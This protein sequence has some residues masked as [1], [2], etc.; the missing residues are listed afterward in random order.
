MKYFLGFVFICFSSHCY[1]ITVEDIVHQYGKPEVISA[2]NKQF[3]NRD[4]TKLTIEF[5]GV[6]RQMQRPSQEYITVKT[7]KIDLERLELKPGQFNKLLIKDLQAANRAKLKKAEENKR[8]RLKQARKSKELRLHG[9]EFDG[10][11]SGMTIPAMKKIA[12]KRQL[13]I[14][15]GNLIY[16][17]GYNQRILDSQPDQRKYTYRTKLMGKL[18][19]VT[20]SFT[21]NTRQLYQV[22]TVF[23]IN[24][25]KP[26]ER[27]YFYDSLFSQLSKKYGN[28]SHIQNKNIGNMFTRFILEP[29]VGSLMLWKPNKNTN[30]F[31]NYKKQYHLLNSFVLTYMNLSL[32]NL[33]KN[34]ITLELKQRT[35]KALSGDSG[36]L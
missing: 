5:N 27:K 16:I 19:T 12:E 29:M 31:L 34:E 14:S 13:P 18:T 24:Q 22:K 32:A 2:L 3:Q 6:I 21:K 26:E 15:P 36:R 30:I 4:N 20:L 1:A 35:D 10:W 33:N 8:L 11:Q 28:P 25:D 9:F 23:H 17:T 7:I